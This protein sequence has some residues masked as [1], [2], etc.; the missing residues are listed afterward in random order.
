MG[1]AM[2]GQLLQ[3]GHTLITLARSPLPLPPQ[4]LATHLHWPHDLTAPE[5][6]AGQLLAWL[7]A[8][9]ASDYASATLINNAAMI[10]PIAPLCATAWPDIA[11]TLRLG[12]EAPMV[13]TSAFLQGTAHWTQ[14]KKVLNISSGLGRR[15]MASQAPYCAAK[16]GLDNFSQA[17]ALEEALKPHGARVC[18][19]AP[20]VIDTAMQAQLR[21]AD[22]D[23]FPDA[24]RLGHLH[25]NGLLTS[26]E[27]A[28][29]Q[30]LAWLARPD[31]GTP[32]LADVRQP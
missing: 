22:A 27:D 23:H 11:A 18:S 21:S 15:G 29:T 7:Q 5:A 28:A 31:F 24:Q 17:L 9:R 14:P 6:A 19:L 30:V 12:L 2:A 8:C 4:P 1:R 26:A 20:G 32:V 10:P 16:A 25:S 3:A 13:L